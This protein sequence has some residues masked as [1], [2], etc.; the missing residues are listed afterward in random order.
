MTSDKKLA[1]MGRKI[2]DNLR[3]IFILKNKHYLKMKGGL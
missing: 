1:T 3:D 2:D